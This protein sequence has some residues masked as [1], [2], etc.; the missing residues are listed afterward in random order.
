MRK[1]TAESF[2]ARIEKRDGCWNWPGA[3]FVSGYGKVRWHGK[4]KL[5]HR[6]AWELARGPIPKG[7]QVCHRYDN[8][9]CI[10]P[11][12]LFLGTMK[13]NMVDKI[14]KG[15]QARGEQCGGSKLTEQAVR[16]MRSR[17]ARGA[18]LTTLAREYG[19]APSHVSK[20][21]S[22]ARWGWLT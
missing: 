11:D 10:N 16:E 4:S 9:L 6:V 15:R 5:A 12:H 1:Q 22:G 21:V 18:S 8:P 14:R 13:D 2:W 17:A 3:R 20:V 7:Q 19:V